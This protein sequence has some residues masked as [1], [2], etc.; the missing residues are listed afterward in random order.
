MENIKVEVWGVFLLKR[1]HVLI[2]EIISFIFFSALTVFLF[3]YD[4]KFH[5]GENYYNFHAKYAKYFSLATTILIIIE[6]QF[7]W[8]RI[9]NAQLELIKKQKK[10][11]EQQ[12]RNINDSLSYA[13][14]IQ[15]ALLPSSKKMDRIL[16]DHFIYYKP[17]DIVSGDFY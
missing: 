1:K 4:F 7:L 6:T 16:S 13:S 17:R 3:S 10:K 5:A 9:S 2:F 15:T 14:R 8:L 11:I 12:N